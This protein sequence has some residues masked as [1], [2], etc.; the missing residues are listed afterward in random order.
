MCRDLGPCQGSAVWGN[1]FLGFFSQSGHLH[2]SCVGSYRGSRGLALECG[3][4]QSS[5]VDRARVSLSCAADPEPPLL[6][7][8]KPGRTSL[9]PA[10]RSPTGIGRLSVKMWLLPWLREAAGNPCKCLACLATESGV[11]S[12]PFGPLDPL[13]W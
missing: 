5:H 6:R 3:G 1:T 10:H 13:P 11:V 2:N 4:H 9:M 12:F 8:D 7:L